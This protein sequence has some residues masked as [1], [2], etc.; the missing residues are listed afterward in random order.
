VHYDR[1]KI[2]FRNEEQ[3]LKEKSKYVLSNFSNI[4]LFGLQITANKCPQQGH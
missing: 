2:I 3:S 4:V 1:C